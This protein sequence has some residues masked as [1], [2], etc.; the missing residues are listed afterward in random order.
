MIRQSA[1]RAAALLAVSESTR[2]D[3]LR[4]LGIPPQK[5]T[6]THLGY[7]PAYIRIEDTARLEQVRQKYHL[8]ARFLLHVGTLEPRKNHSTL[9]KAFDI[10]AHS[11]PEIAL[12]L[13]GGAGWNAQQISRQIKEMRHGDRIY[14]LGYTGR[15]DMP[16]LYRLAEVF[17]YPSIYEGY[18]LPVLEAM[19]CGTPTITSTVSSM[20]EIIGDAGILVSPDNAVELSAAMLELLGNPQL[21]AELTQKS[22][23]RAL[24]FSWRKTA[25]Q[26]LQ[27]YERNH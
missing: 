23:K 19:A 1:A 20:P 13:V 26:T 24:G 17:V 14:R 9:L 3:S 2:Q 27:I 25:E 12:V 5:I 10:I 22:Q 8:P 11:Y 7:D 16:A 6:T 21:A 4:L 15:E 18:G